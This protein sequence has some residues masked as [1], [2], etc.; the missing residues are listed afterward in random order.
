M[1]RLFA[2]FVFVMAGLLACNV[3]AFAVTFVVRATPEG[4]TVTIEGKVLPAPG[5][6]DLKRRDEPYEITVQKS[7]YQT[8]TVSYSTKQKLKEISVAL[9][10]LQIQREVT[11]KANVDGATVTIDGKAAGTTPF[12]K[13]VTFTRP[14]KTSAWLPLTV[15]VAKADYQTESFRLT[16]DKP[17]PAP[18]TLA[19]LRIERT[20]LVSAKTGESTAVEAMLS[21]GDRDLGVAPQKVPVVFTRADK[22][23]PWPVFDLKGEIPS[24]YQP[25]QAKLTHDGFDNVVLT[26]KPVTE[27]PVALFS[28]AIEMTPTGARLT[29]NQST[30]LGLLDSS[31]HGADITGLSRLT[32]FLRRDQNAKAPLQALNGY[33]IT[34]DG[35]SAILSLTGQDDAGKYFSGLFLK[36]VEDDG[37]GVAR[38]IDNNK[39]YYDCAPV[40]APDSSNILVFQ[41]NRGDLSKPDVFRI[42]FSD[43]RTSG[44]VARIT[45]DQRF[46]YSPTYTDSNREV[47]YLSIEPNY[48]LA[49]PQLSTVKMDGALP[50]Q[51]QINADEVSHREPTKI[52]LT[53][54]DQSNGKRQIYSVEPDGRLETAI[55]SDDSFLNANCFNPVAS[56][57]NPVR[58]LFVSDR[59]A[60]DQGRHNNNIYVMNAD[61]SQIQQLTANGSDDIQPAWSPTDPNIVYFL[62]NRGGAYNLWRLRIK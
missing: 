41:S 59:D 23:K 15:T 34:P 50:T 8:E 11:I 43:N 49:V 47:V 13:A 24:I 27:L 26:L 45:N 39:R 55:I 46:N 7:G 3:T 48:P 31:E 5:T 36:R 54:P 62:S 19:Q 58:I 20:F 21:L 12:T 51:F 57:S 42:S 53:R 37:G 29:V 25:V 4:A 22:T 28:P 10:P 14:D 17:S 1:T 56:F 2:R 61:G 44:G 38:L 35:Q 6:F 40:I 30:K 33:A 52:Y 32:R 9:E 16:E 18:V 60:D